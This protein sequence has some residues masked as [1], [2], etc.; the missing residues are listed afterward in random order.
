MISRYDVPAQ[1]NVQN[2]YVPLPY[3]ELAHSLAI[4]QNEYDFLHQKTE[5]A[6]K[7]IMGIK[8]PKFI[9]TSTDYSPTGTVENPQAQILEQAQEHFAKK[10]E[11]LLNSGI[12]YTTPEGKKAVSE[13]INQ[14]G[15]FR[16]TA[17]KQIEQDSE[18]IKE[19]N[20]NHDEYLKKGVNYSGNAY[21]SDRNVD[22][23]L[24]QGSNFETTSL[25]PYQERTKIVGEALDKMKSQVISTRDKNGLVTLKDR[26]SGIEVATI[27][28]GKT[29]WKG[30]SGERVKNALHGVVDSELDE[31]LQREASSYRDFLIGKNSDKIF[32]KNGNV[33]QVTYKAKDSKGKEVEVT[34]SAD[35]YYY[36]QKYNKLRKDLQDYALNTFVSSDVTS[37]Q[38]NKALSGDFQKGGEQDPSRQIPAVV[39]NTANVTQGSSSTPA[40]DALPSLLDKYKTE[41]NKGRH[42]TGL[43]FHLTE[44]DSKEKQETF[45]D[46]LLN[47]IQDSNDKKKMEVLYNHINSTN[48]QSKGESDKDYLTRISNEIDNRWKNVVSDKKLNFAPT[49]KSKAI[50]DN[51][52]EFAKSI[53]SGA[54]VTNEKGEEEDFNPDTDYKFGGIVVKDNGVSF[55]MYDTKDPK[56][57]IQIHNPSIVG[58]NDVAIQR[59]SLKQIGNEGNVNTNNLI[60]EIVEHAKSNSKD[61]DKVVK[62]KVEADPNNNE[63]VSVVLLDKEGRRVGDKIPNEVLD[64]LT[65]T[66]V[67]KSIGAS[68]LGTTPQFKNSK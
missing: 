51:I 25:N 9:R 68:G 45:K 63:L 4:K 47:S 39:T 56:K 22:K 21:Y 14:V 34:D 24:N 54:T 23:F 36:N 27:Q 1:Q 58:A 12:D 43:P 2:T 20:K 7:E 35:K 8:V 32:D 52:G 3:A 13:Y 44:K 40:K 26:N 57:V 15:R 42:D 30:V 48:Y 10:K 19:H 61:Y 28:N 55:N 16:N 64:Q 38:N 41:E 5:E 53:V 62:Y 50:N 49:F 65:L 29:T 67:A 66:T 33:R 37:T 6:D 59:S 31:G 18:N 17:G 11:D 46:N 60:N